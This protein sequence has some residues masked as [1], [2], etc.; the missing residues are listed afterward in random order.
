[1]VGKIPCQGAG[2]K[3]SGADTRIAA[4]LKETPADSIH[5]KVVHTLAE[6]GSVSAAELARLTGLARSTISTALSDLRKSGVVVAAVAEGTKGVGRPAQTL[7]LN[8]EA[9]TCIGIHLSIAEIGLVVADVSHSFVS[10]QTLHLRRDY[11][12]AEALALL[13][14]AVPQAYR[15]NGLPLSGLLGAGISVSGPVTPDGVILQASILPR[16]A[17]VNVREVFAPAL[18]VPLFADNESNCAALAEMMWGAAQ[19]VPEFV[20]FKIDLGVGG[21]IVHGGRV[22]TGVAGG[23]GEFGHMTVDPA[24]PLCRCGNRGCLERYAAFDDPL[25]ELSR[26]HGRAM[27]IS[28]A[29]ALARQGDVGAQRLIHDSAVAAG[30]GLASIG[31]VLN[32]PLILIG[33]RLALADDLVLAPLTDA[34]ERHTLIRGASVPPARR[35]RIRR[36]RFTDKDSL[37]GA[38]GL[39]LRGRGRL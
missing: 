15:R 20:L 2:N 7:S 18:G 25:D 27:T 10:E 1:M 21:A 26:V 12:P 38:V 9:G 19:G 11:T 33:G 29:I 4:L 14:D 24:G 36:G 34:Y 30:R 31:T 39:V 32:P 37:L 3:V 8:P 6:T 28:E 16:W 23:A 13:R 17:G 5:A 22:M 35:T